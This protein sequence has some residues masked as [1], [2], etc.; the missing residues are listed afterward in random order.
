MGMWREAN[1][2]KVSV[3]LE[4]VLVRGLMQYTFWVP[5]GSPEHRYCLHEAV[6]ECNHTL[7]FQEMVNRIGV[8]VPGMPR[9]LRWISHFSRYTLARCRRCSS[10]GCWRV[11]SRSNTCRR[12]CYA[13]ASRCIRSWRGSWRSTWPRRPATSRLLTN[14]CASGSRA[15]GATAVLAF[16][17]RADRHAGAVPGDRRAAAR[18]LEGIRHPAVGA[19]GVFSTRPNRARRCATCSATSGCCAT[20][21]G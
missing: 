3:H 11:R 8:N 19:K 1:I 10:S 6:E 17:V 2:A 20:T 21:W 12:T 13:K 9:I 7:M 14:T 18:L 15:C 5:T 16:A 4:S